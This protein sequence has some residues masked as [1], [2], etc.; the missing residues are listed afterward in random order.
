MQTV[1]PI[2]DSRKLDAMKKYLKGK[3]LRDYALF[4]LG[5]NTGLRN[6]DLK[7]LKVD[8]VQGNNGKIRDRIY[9]H[10]KKTGKEKIFRVNET[11]QKALKEYLA[12]RPGAGQ[13]ELLFP[14]RE[15]GRELTSQQIR[16]II[17]EAA[18]AVGVT[19]RIGTTSL[20]KTFGY[21]AR[22]KGVPVEVLMRIFNHSW[23][24]VTL[25]Y[26]GISQDELEEVYLELNI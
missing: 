21:H 18:R 19:E 11:A 15:G 24:H 14:S 12:T 5:I 16:N 4:V 17:L 6:G 10:E 13:E 9:I 20:R 8:D 1:E 25:R 3:N 22:R 23:P 26:I 2:R 7:S